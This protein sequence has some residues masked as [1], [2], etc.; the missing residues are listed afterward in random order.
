M[1][2]SMELA[3]TTRA[4]EHVEGLRGL[5]NNYLGAGAEYHSTEMRRD[6]LD[7]KMNVQRFIVLSLI[8]VVLCCY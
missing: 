3:T 1:V 4:P 2:A 8:E 6:F 5:E 7:L